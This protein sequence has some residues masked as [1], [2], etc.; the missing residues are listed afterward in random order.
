MHPSDWVKK[1]V[2]STTLRDQNVTISLHRLMKTATDPRV[3][4]PGSRFS[5]APGAP[6][7]Q[8]TVPNI[9]DTRAKAN[10]TIPSSTL[11]PVGSFPAA[12]NRNALNFM[13][14]RRERGQGK[15]P[16]PLASAGGWKPEEAQTQVPASV[17]HVPSQEKVIVP[18]QATSPLR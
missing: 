14:Q 8:W 10:A 11:S 2:E 12:P 9:T 13:L 15:H 3:T 4:G 7:A 1:P 17:R 5:P 18:T 16:E 6:A